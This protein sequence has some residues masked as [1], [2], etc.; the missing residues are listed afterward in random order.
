VLINL[1]TSTI[2]PHSWSST[3]G[4][5]TIDYFPTTMA[6]V[7]NQT[8]DIQEQIQDLLASLRRLQDQ[9]VALEI[10]FI[11]IEDDFFERIGVDF[12]LNIVT[13]Q[14]TAKV[15]P[16]LIQ[17]AFQAPN[18]INQFTPKNLI[19]GLTSAG[20]LT[21]NLDIPI[22][23]NTFQG[24]VPSFGGYIP[25]G[26][27]L[28]LAFLSDI[29]VFLFMEAAQGNT[30]T[31]VM[32]APK[33]TLFNGQ[34]AFLTVQ[35]QQ[36]FV[37]S[38]S[39]ATLANGN[40]VFVPLTTQ[41]STGGVTLQLQAVISADRRF[42]R[43]T[44]TVTLTNLVPGPV[45]T[46]PIVLPIF[47]GLSPAD[48]NGTAI[49]FTQLIQQPATNSVTVATT[50]AVPDGGTVLMGG[51]KRLSEARSENGP[52]ILSKIP[53]L[54]RL[55]KN[56]GIGRETRHVMLMITPRIIINAEEEIFQTEGRTGSDG[57]P[58]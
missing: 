54:N 8:G 4:P 27:S 48:G 29:Q 56:V 9:E 21:S 14:E 50:V 41:V 36:S 23:N 12:S 15:Q 37:T 19:T 57:P 28:G 26:L 42:V 55:F 40:P 16:S 44:P 22:Q 58:R 52:P 49:V 24:T 30:R 18:Q 2:E 17:N 32:Q 39:V 35:D 1:I 7:V 5:G 38:A 6:L 43:L 31:N 20:A 45:G 34:T 53:Y 11:S 51:L 10:R 33:L 13:Q 47:P 46:F 25:G 3:G